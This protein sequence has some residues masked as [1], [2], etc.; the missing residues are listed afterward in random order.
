M[1][2]NNLKLKI[3]KAKNI[4]AG[5]RHKAF[6]LDENEFTTSETSCSKSIKTKTIWQ[7]TKDAEMKSL[8]EFEAFDR[9]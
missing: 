2:L 5:N 4:I 8:L 7:S 6:G 9:P 1:K 3:Q